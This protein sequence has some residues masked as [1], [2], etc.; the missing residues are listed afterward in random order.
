MSKYLKSLWFYLF[1]VIVL[2]LA[3]ALFSPMVLFHTFI[4]KE[5]DP[6]IFHIV[7]QLKSVEAALHEIPPSRLSHYIHQ[8]NQTPNLKI[9]TQFP[10]IEPSTSFI[11]HEFL[12]EFLPKKLGPEY[13]VFF[14]KKGIYIS[15]LSQHEELWLHFERQ[16]MSLLFLRLFLFTLTFNFLV[17]LFL[18]IFSYRHIGKPIK[19]LI[20][21]AHNFR[22]GLT[23][24]DIPP[25]GPSELKQLH[26]A[27]NTMANDVRQY[28]QDRSLALAGISHD[29]RTP[30]SR[31][32]L[33][34]EINEKN[35]T[36]ASYTGMVE[37]IEDMDNIMSEFI[38]VLKN[39]KR[40]EVRPVDI[41][42]LVELLIRRY[43]RQG[44]SFQTSLTQ[45]PQIP[46]QPLVLIRA[47]S[48][49]IDNALYHGA[50]PIAITTST[51]NEGVVFSV[52]DCGQSITPNKLQ[53]LNT[54]LSLR[55]ADSIEE[56]GAGLGLLIVQRITEMHHGQFDI[57]RPNNGG[58]E[59]SIWLPF[60]H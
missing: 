52:S 57:K 35:F 16:E 4:G 51:K 7:R 38:S 27:F 10:K 18:V 56:S 14:S 26:R 30:L 9:E 1:I 23:P 12:P 5:K 28:Y 24:N 48:N 11:H 55:D 33:A 37:D 44:K 17:A 32:R 13:T 31:L 49:L 42:E 20:Q 53:E 6:H 58:L 47:F 45:L 54:W 36:S 46:A 8:L 40:E 19:N 43:D 60:R 39:K 21:A 34:I 2:Q 15:L 50:Q 3:I 22:K 25:S 41:N 59:T 29:L